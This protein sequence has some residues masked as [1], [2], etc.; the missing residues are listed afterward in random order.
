MSRLCIDESEPFVAFDIIRYM[1]KSLGSAG[2]NYE[3]D[4]RRSMLS[5]ASGL[6][7]EVADSFE[8]ALGGEGSGS[9]LTHDEWTDLLAR[10]TS[11]VVFMTWQWQQLWW[12]HF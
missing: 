10:A 3:R 8:A 9:L 6:N 4:M 1:C 2:R 11:N 7:L 12:R 5:T